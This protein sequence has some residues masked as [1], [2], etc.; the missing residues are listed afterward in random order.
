M[1][2]VLNTLVTVY[3]GADAVRTYM[4]LSYVRCVMILNHV[5]TEF[6]PYV[7]GSD[8]EKQCCPNLHYRPHNTYLWPAAQRS[9]SASA[10]YSNDK[11][12]RKCALRTE[13][14]AGWVET[15][16]AISSEY[17]AYV[18]TEWPRENLGL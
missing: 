2:Q 1:G 15:S 18:R 14:D 5:D 12:F 6:G 11:V 7:G 10:P 9:Y 4:K 13:G 16:R 3:K 8:V 17:E